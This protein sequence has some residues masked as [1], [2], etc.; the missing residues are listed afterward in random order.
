MFPGSSDEAIVVTQKD[1]AIWKVSLSGAFA[2]VL[3]ADISDRVGTFGNEEGLLS[4]AFSPQFQSDGRVYVY[5][6]KKSNVP[7]ATVL[8]RFQFANGVIDTGSEAVILEVPDFA[9]N[10]NGGRIAFGKD[11]FLY[12]STGDG[13][14]GGDPD[15]NGQNPNTLL[16]KVLRLNVTGQQAYA[17]PP[18]NPFVGADGADEVWAYGFRN[19]WRMSVDSATGDIWLGDV[20]QGKWEE[21]DRVVRGGNHGWDCYEGFAVFESSGCSGDGFVQPRAVYTLAGEECAVSGGFVYRGG[22]IPSLYGYYVY[23]DFC[24]GKVWAVNTADGSDPVLLADTTYRISSFAE[25][26]GGELAVLTFN[27]AIYKLVS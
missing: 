4:A 21:V 10:H 13:G 3:L 18:D 1:A 6:T 23:A 24:S 19:P 12:L 5:Y 14:G 16:G 2:P 15:E 8:S 20:G 11:G 9:E 26:P 17:V 27:R 7:T 22:A 25:L